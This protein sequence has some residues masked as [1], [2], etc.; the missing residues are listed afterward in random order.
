[1]DKDQIE[2]V[3]ESPDD[4]IEA[5]EEVKKPSPEEI[6]PKRLKKFADLYLLVVIISSLGLAAAITVAVMLDLL[7]G[8]VIA[9]ASLFIYTRFTASE[10]RDR[11][12]ISYKTSAGSLEITKVKVRYGDVFFIPSRLVWYDVERIAD[13]AFFSPSGKNAELRAV[14]L[15]RSIK[16]I[17]KDVFASCNSLCEV[18]FEGSASE[19]EKI[20]KLTSFDELEVS[21]DAAYPTK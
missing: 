14:Y 5:T 13:G 6:Y 18:H 8:A 11:L 2:Q 9:L 1:M 7:W 4:T 16:H 3:T 12:G 20:E 15:P 19:W 21:F 17:G 10:L